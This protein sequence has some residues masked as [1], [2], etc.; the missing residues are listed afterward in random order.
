MDFLG[1]V[2]FERGFKVELR[3]P[4]PPSMKKSTTIGI[5]YSLDWSCKKQFLQDPWHCKHGDLTNALV[6]FNEM[7]TQGLYPDPSIF[8]II[9]TRLGKQGKWDIIKKNFEQMKD[10]V[11]HQTQFSVA[12]ACSS[13]QPRNLLP[14]IYTSALNNNRPKESNNDLP[15]T[16][17][18]TEG[19]FRKRK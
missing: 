9:I 7:Q 1:F 19:G 6:L 5:Q 15:V 18:T 12:H 3:I 2:E 4:G 11:K 17:N 13:K 14:V 16:W 10:G 8:I